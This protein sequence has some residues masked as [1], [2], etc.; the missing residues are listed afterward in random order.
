MPR[1]VREEVRVVKRVL[2]ARRGRFLLA[3]LDGGPSAIF[4]VKHRD[5]STSARSLALQM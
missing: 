3:F 2:L 4:R 5:A 1:A